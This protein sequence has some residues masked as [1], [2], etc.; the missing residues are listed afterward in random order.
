MSLPSL[1][2]FVETKI[3]EVCQISGK[4]DPEVRAIYHKI[5]TETQNNPKNANAFK[6][7][8]ELHSYCGRIL[9][10]RT[11]MRT[12]DAEAEILPIGGGGA[13][14]TKKG[15]AQDKVYALIKEVEKPDAPAVRVIMCMREYAILPSQVTYY[16]Q[17]RDHIQPGKDGMYW[18]SPNTKFGNPTMIALTP[19]DIWEKLG[20][21][22][23]TTEQ[24]EKDEYLSKVRSDGYVD[25][26]DFKLIKATVARS[27]TGKRKDGTD[28][29]VYTIIDDS[30]DM[31][32]QQKDPQG[33]TIGPG[34]SV[35]MPP[36]LPLYPAESECWFLGTT[37][38]NAKNGQFSMQG[39]YVHS[40]YSEEVG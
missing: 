17:Y 30:T 19:K 18:A 36:Y 22:T 16:A 5:L 21:P 10:V 28:F 31:T 20:Y 3:G 13:R 4:P 24:A 9:F 38:K 1:P 29:A 12:D 11:V 23:I 2:S 27:N 35:W 15:E 33:R 26:L 7:P 32:R 39:V 25:E 6:T 40:T 14:I 8:E 37:R 34:Y